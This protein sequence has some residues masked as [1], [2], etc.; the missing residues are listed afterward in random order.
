MCI[1]DRFSA[2]TLEL[3]PSLDK[4]EFARRLTARAAEM[5]GA[6][7]YTHLNHDVAAENRVV[8]LGK[9]FGLQVVKIELN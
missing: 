8:A 9:I 7:S 1:R 6:V 2:A 5:L 3:N 4:P